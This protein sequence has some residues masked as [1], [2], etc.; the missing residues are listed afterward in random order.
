MLSAESDSRLQDVVEPK[1]EINKKCRSEELKSVE[2]RVKM[3]EAKI[4]NMLEEAETTRGQKRNDEG[5]YRPSRGFQRCLEK[6]QL[7]GGNGRRI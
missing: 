6:R 4:T 7:S 2:E 1:D 3:L 5:F